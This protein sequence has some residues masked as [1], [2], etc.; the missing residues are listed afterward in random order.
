MIMRE[1]L[2]RLKRNYSIKISVVS[3]STFNGPKTQADLTKI[4]R[5]ITTILMVIGVAWGK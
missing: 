2:N 5:H 3:G 1:M 4:Q